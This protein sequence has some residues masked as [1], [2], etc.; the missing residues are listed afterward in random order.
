MS[1]MRTT[2]KWPCGNGYSV[3][4]EIYDSIAV[5]GSMKYK[6]VFESLTRKWF[7]NGSMYLTRQGTAIIKDGTLWLGC[8]SFPKSLDTTLYWANK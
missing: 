8:I 1:I 2:Y 4:F 5:P 3:D 6:L 7:G